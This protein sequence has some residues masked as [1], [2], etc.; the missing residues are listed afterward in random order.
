MSASYARVRATEDAATAAKNKADL[1]AAEVSNN[2]KHAL[3]G[4]L[5]ILR[6]G[7]RLLVFVREWWLW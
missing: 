3:I 7:G 5:L 1:D 2:K 4:R 6:C